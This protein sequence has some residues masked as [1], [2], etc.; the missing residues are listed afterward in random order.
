MSRMR[1]CKRC[2]TCCSKGGPA[3]HTEDLPLIDGRHLTIPDLITIRAGEPV[4]SPL[5][6]TIEPSRSEL[7]KLAGQ[8]DSWTCHFFD[9]AQ[10]LCGIYANRP[11]EC[12]LL[13]C[14]ETADLT[15]VIY[16]H[17]LSRHD[18]I[19]ANDDLWELIT[20]Q[21]EHCEFAKIAALAAEFITTCNSTTQTEI[22]RIVSLDLKIRQRAIQLRRLSVAEELLYFGRP[23]FKSLAFYHLT[24][25]EGPHGITV[26]S[27][28]S[29]GA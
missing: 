5:V 12:R 11:L 6:N 10:N 24:L 18:I 19:P 21:E 14:W 8:D 13:K 16:Q 28:S 29:L 4:F 17:C 20:I 27:A 2:G 23:L 3:L 9:Q 25:H 7:I 22:G 15:Q 26:H 1:S